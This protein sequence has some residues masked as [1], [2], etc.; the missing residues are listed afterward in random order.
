[1]PGISAP[2]ARSRVIRREWHLFTR[3]RTAVPSIL[4]TRATTAFHQV[5]FR[6]L[7]TICGLEAIG[8]RREILDNGSEL[9]FLVPP[10]GLEPRTC[11]LKVR[12]S[13]N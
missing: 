13:T 4:H 9:A 6:P 1:M 2:D 10:L 8:L 12:S 11:G 5:S 7:P 3:A